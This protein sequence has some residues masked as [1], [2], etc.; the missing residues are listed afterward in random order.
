M[1]L[2]RG[3]VEARRAYIGAF[4]NQGAIY[5]FSGDPVYVLW[6]DWFCVRLSSFGDV[7]QSGA[8]CARELMGE[9]LKL[10]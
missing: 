10:S 5:E 3:C 2:E 7:T 1:I 6:Q 8:V 9:Q 4:P